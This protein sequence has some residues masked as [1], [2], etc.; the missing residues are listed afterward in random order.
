MAKWLNILNPGEA[1]ETDA[2]G[3]R[4]VLKPHRKWGFPGCKGCPL[5]HPA[6]KKLI[7][8]ERIA[9]R[10]VMIWGSF[11]T[12]EDIREGLEFSSKGGRWLF[13]R[14]EKVGLTRDDVD[15]QNVVRCR[16]VKRTGGIT[17][18]REVQEK[19]IYHCSYH[20][21]KALATNDKKANVHLVL[22]Q[23]A[24]KS[25][26]GKEYKKDR[27]VFYSE[28]L[29]ARV[30]VLDHP[31][32]FVRGDGAPEWRLKAFRQRLAVAKW[33]S[34]RPGKWA[35]LEQSD[36]KAVTTRKGARQLFRRLRKAAEQGERISVDI[37]DGKV[38]GERKL[39]CIGFS[40]A[41]DIARSVVVDHPGN[42]RPQNRN[43]LLKLVLAFLADPDIEFAFH[44]GSSDTESLLHTFGIR[45]KGY[46]YDTTYANYLRYTFLKGH[47][48][49]KI[50]DLFYPEYSGYKEYITPH[51]PQRKKQKTDNDEQDR[52][53]ANY[54]DIPLDVLTRYNCADAALTKRIEIDTRDEIS[55][56]LLQTYCW[57]GITLHRMERRGPLLDR[58]YLEEVVT[59]IVPRRVKELRKQLQLLAGDPDFNPNT[60]EEV[61]SV[62]YDKL[63]LPVLDEDRDGNPVRSTKEEV[64][65]MLKEKTKSKFPGLLLE[66]RKY[67]KMESTYLANYD[68]SARLHN[69]RLRTKWY[70]TGAVTG[71]LRSGGSRDGYEGV[72][73][74]QNLHGSAF[75]Q[76]LLISDNGWRAA[77][78]KEF[79]DV[80]KLP[81]DILDLEVFIAY[82]YSQIEIRMLA[83]VSGDKLL[84]KQFAD[85]AAMEDPS[86][87]RADI[88][89]IVGNLLN[90]EWSLEFIKKD[91]P[92]RTFIKNCHFGMVYGLDPSGLYYYLLAKGVDTT[93]KKVDEFHAA[94]F[95]KYK[96]VGRF[97]EKM[98]AFAREHHYVDTIFGF[99]RRIGNEMEEGRTTNPDNQA[100]NSP[101]QGAAHQLLLNGMALLYRKPKTYNLLQKSIME[102]HDALVFL[103]KVRDLPQAY[104]QGKQLLEVEIPKYVKEVFGRT[105]HVPLASEATAGFRYGAMTDYHGAKPVEFIKAWRAKNETVD[106]KVAEEFKIA[107]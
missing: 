80:P 7:N 77:I 97:I 25:L 70:L 39:L 13:K 57:A 53:E 65:E 72:I 3:R 1:I 58:R 6:A 104:A 105:L 62:M 49:A 54:A 85:A 32:F 18:E 84:L 81:D 17:Y 21:G 67:S 52:I 73:N 31:S 20:N 2:K 23:L 4:A 35:F 66:Y 29:E 46:T 26:L 45:I 69:G 99:R 44:Y 55:L 83:E 30:F 43:Y 37:E 36:F 48:L 89:C 40:W 76:N 60:P 92:T 74:M 71:R 107:A 94:Y 90:P 28:R 42:P 106:K 12:K 86:D 10:K 8:I 88:H 56:P 79:F 41:K 100:I 75:L 96:G 19:E 16:P 87:P 82:D 78:D 98:R 63:K 61:A 101:I 50:A 15:V 22:G 24:A 68:K 51:L 38:D 34:R 5:D 14:L 9:G 27:P 11:P 33:F 59:P 47:G 95:D 64:L 102:V 93:Q 91:K 103:V